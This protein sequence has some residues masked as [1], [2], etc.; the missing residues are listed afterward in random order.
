MELF[1]VSALVFISIVFIYYQ[2]FKPSKTKV[3][4][5][6]TIAESYSRLSEDNRLRFIKLV[7]SLERHGTKY[8]VSYG[9]VINY[10]AFTIS[11][12]GLVNELCINFVER[13]ENE[14]ILVSVS[15][16][17]LKMEYK[18]NEL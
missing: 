12:H 10:K 1:L 9:N 17:V 18:R 15:E 8:A 5:T 16:Y 6:D 11:D 13:K 3:Y 14:L 7:K 2:I 4:L